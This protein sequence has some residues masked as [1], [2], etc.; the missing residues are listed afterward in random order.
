[1][2]SL[3]LSAVNHEEASVPLI[4]DENDKLVELDVQLKANQINRSFATLRLI[5]DWNKFSFSGIDSMSRVQKPNGDVA[6]V[7]ERVATGDTLSYQV[8]GVVGNRSVNGT[9]ADY[10]SY[11]GG[12]DYRCVIRT[13]PGETVKITLDPSK[14]T[15]SS[16]DGLPIVSFHN[17]PFL[18]Y[19]SSLTAEVN[20]MREASY[21]MPVGGGPMT[22]SPE[23]HQALLDYVTKEFEKQKKAGNTRS[24]Q[25]AAITLAG[26]YR[27]DDASAKAAARTILEAVPATSPL[28]M[29]DARAATLM[30]DLVDKH[31]ADTYR[32]GLESNPE[33]SV[34]AIAFGDELQR[35]SQAK[36]EKEIRRLYAQ[37]KQDYGDVAEIKY[38]LTEANPDA[39]V[40]VGK[41]IPSFD[42]TLMDGSGNASDK[43]MLGKY[44]MIDFWAT[45]CGPCVAEMPAMHKAYEKYKG[46][47]G[48]EIISLSMDA[49][50]NQVAPFR[51][52]WKMPWLHAFLPGIF[53]A[54]LAKKFEVAWIPSPIL[55]GPDG[56]I[57][58]TQ[59]N[60]R[61][62]EL[63]KTLEKYLGESD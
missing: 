43:S 44:Y 17:N 37:I 18:Q 28:W 49:A 21:I 41:S 57:V 33:R 16:N 53:D 46:R 39:L 35:A 10:Y 29:L 55:V 45:W 26:A 60:L 20:R 61:G 5:G 22:I 7:A 19:V 2:Y 13:K 12:G 24:M 31:V 14:Y 23:K 30:A 1:M 15:Y 50:E 34:R 36:D 3:R 6:F 58:A 4:L 42:V 51:K 11:D 27:P 40:R 62:E 32:K 52:K 56:K 8:L 38:I 48:F 47:K 9:E 54:E 25:F 59:D 63:E